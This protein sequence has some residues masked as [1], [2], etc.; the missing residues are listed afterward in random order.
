VKVSVSITAYNHEKFIAQA[1]ES[2][3]MQE[4]DFDYEIIIGEDDS[5]DRTREIVKAYYEKY[6]EKIRLF[7]NDR[8]NVIYVDGRA[9]GPAAPG[10]GCERT[11]AGRFRQSAGLLRHGAR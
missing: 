5:T 1:I 6:P 8:K 2:V 9:T 3:L 4:T 10:K 7:L 11:G